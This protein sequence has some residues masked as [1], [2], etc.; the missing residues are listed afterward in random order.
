MTIK[1]V[2]I[3]SDCAAYAA[4]GAAAVEVDTEMGRDLT[5]A[6]NSAPCSRWERGSGG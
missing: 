6:G 5:P 1:N 3:N 4:S 2:P